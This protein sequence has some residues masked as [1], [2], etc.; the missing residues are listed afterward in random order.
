MGW[1]DKKITSSDQQNDPVLSLAVHF[2]KD[3]CQQ[4]LQRLFND[5]AEHGGIDV[6]V[7]SLQRKHALFRAMFAANAMDTLDRAQFDILIDCVFSAR[8]RLTKVLAAMAW[9]DLV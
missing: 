7:V 9:D 2:D 5:L 8:R 1:F 3:I 4:V 6:C